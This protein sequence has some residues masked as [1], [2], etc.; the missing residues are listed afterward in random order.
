MSGP[1][2]DAGTHRP[3]REEGAQPRRSAGQP[4]RAGRIL[5]LRGVWIAP[6]VITAVLIALITVIYIG[7]VVNPTG[8]IHGLPVMVVNRDAGATVHGRR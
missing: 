1:G 2:E 6:L 8:H 5:R 3:D 7:A 4:V